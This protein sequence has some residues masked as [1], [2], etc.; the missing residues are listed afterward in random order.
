MWSLQL[1]GRQ[2]TGPLYTTRCGGAFLTGCIPSRR[3][4]V[5]SQTPDI[6]VDP[7]ARWSSGGAAE[8]CRAYALASDDLHDA[9]TRSRR[10][11]GLR[12]VI[13]GLQAKCRVQ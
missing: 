2:T 9:W 12:I 7:I 1:F 6:A 3:R 8:E 13:G 10:H 11:R 5:G 4:R